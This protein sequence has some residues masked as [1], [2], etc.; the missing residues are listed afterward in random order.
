VKPALPGATIGILGGG[1]LGRMLA[2][3]ARRMGYRVAVL[4]PARDCPAA[5]VCDAHVTAPLDDAEAAAKLAGLCDVVTLEWELIGLE[6]IRSAKRRCP[7]FPGESVL[8]PI[9]DR[10]R[11]RQFLAERG[12]P[13]TRFWPVDDA[14]SLQDAARQAGLP[15]VLKRRRH[16]YDGK[17]QRWLLRRPDVA[18]A[19]ELLAAP[20]VLEARVPFV[21]ELSVIVARGRDGG[22]AAFPPI[23]NVHHGGI[24]HSS[25]I[26]A[27]VSKATAR[28]AAKLGRR[29]AE[30]LGH[31]GVLAVE[32][33]LLEDGRL[34]VNEIAP[35][36]HNSGH[37]TWGACR[38]SQFEQHIRAVCGLPLDQPRLLS[39]GAM[40]NLL[41]ELWAKRE[42]RWERALARPVALHLYGKGQARPGRKMGH[43]IALE[44]T[45]AAALRRAEGA[46]RELI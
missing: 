29:V 46:W 9:Q 7:V 10:L 27:G 3:E 43:L 37:V 14:P 30:A 5:A 12:F 21:K 22:M 18:S 11:Q 23:E 44:R 26:P 28:A 41:G 34:L 2:L 39:P 20:C 8:R 4:D 38:V 24:L 36:V 32:L 17:G 31:V 42:P 35:R 16:G 25:V 45:T 33:F 13:Q 19:A 15:C 40:V 6:A 1:Q